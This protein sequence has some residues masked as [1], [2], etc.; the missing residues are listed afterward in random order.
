MNAVE[1]GNPKCSVC[2]EAPHIKTTNHL[3]LDLPK[4]SDIFYTVDNCHKIR[5]LAPRQSGQIFR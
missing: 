3:F 2:K 4:V 1:L 5:C